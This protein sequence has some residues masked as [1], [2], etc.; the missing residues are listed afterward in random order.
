MKHHLPTIHIKKI[1]MTASTP[2]ALTK[3]E[4]PSTLATHQL[5][6][7]LAITLKG[8][9]DGYHQGCCLRRNGTTDLETDHPKVIDE[10]SFSQ[11]SRDVRNTRGGNRRKQGE[12]KVVAHQARLRCRLLPSWFCYACVI[13]VRFICCHLPPLLPVRLTSNRFK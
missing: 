2:A 12:G 1:M 3:C 7:I 8:Q 5:T 10:G 9:V 4:A 13:R 6:Q 11:V